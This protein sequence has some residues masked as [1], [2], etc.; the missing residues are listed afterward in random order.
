[1]HRH[2]SY[3]SQLAKR[4]MEK[5]GGKTWART[6]THCQ[7]GHGDGSC[8]VPSCLSS[9]LRSIVL[10]TARFSHYTSSVH[11]TGG[12]SSTQRWTEFND[13]LPGTSGTHVEQTSSHVPAETLHAFSSLSSRDLGRGLCQQPCSC[14]SSSGQFQSQSLTAQRMEIPQSGRH[15]DSQVAGAEKFVSDEFVVLTFYRTETPRRLQVYF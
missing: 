12:T 3:L 6:K 9:A 8:K 15:I 5:Q 4:G 14:L 10:I 2:S 11:Q 13:G 7:H 1:M